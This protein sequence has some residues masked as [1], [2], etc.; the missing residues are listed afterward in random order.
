MLLIGSGG[1]GI[2]PPPPTFAPQERLVLRVTSVLT[3]IAVLL[4]NT[5]PFSVRCYLMHDF[6]C[7]L[8]LLQGFREIFTEQTFSWLK[9]SGAGLFKLLV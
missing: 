8:E 4:G 7:S 1:K 6:I 3:S 2:P 9:G 5:S